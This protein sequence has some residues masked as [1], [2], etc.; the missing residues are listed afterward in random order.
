MNGYH[1]LNEVGS[2]GTLSSLFTILSLFTENVNLAWPDASG[3]E[4]EFDDGG[5]KIP[6]GPPGPPS[7]STSTIIGA[8]GSR[9]DALQRSRV[10]SDVS[11]LDLTS[12][13]QADTSPDR[14]IS[15]ASSTASLGVAQDWEPIA[16]PNSQPQSSHRPAARP[17]PAS[18]AS[19]QFP[20]FSASSALGGSVPGRPSVRVRQASY[21]T[22][23]AGAGGSIARA[24]VD[25]TLAVIPAGTSVLLAL[26]SSV[27]NK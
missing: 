18:V 14:G 20:S 21:P 7:E 23:L 24:T 11:H 13:S 25:T 1:L 16:S 19:S 4:S 27:S 8:N 10:N 22:G 3:E 5:L 2:G 26:T 17:G 9:G 6:R 15:L 12:L